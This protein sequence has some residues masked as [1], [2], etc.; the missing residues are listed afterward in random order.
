MVADTCYNQEMGDF[1]QGRGTGESE[2]FLSTGL[3]SPEGTFPFDSG[4]NSADM[5]IEGVL[6]QM[7]LDKLSLDQDV[8][9]TGNGDQDMSSPPRG[10]LA[11]L[12]QMLVPSLTSPLELPPS[13]VQLLKK[14]RTMEGSRAGGMHAGDVW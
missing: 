10:P 14:M 4:V 2:A 9:H 7:P 5:N 3:S 1:V 6:C 13:P 11:K 12:Q 8:A